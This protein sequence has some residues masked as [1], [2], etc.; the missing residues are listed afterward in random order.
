MSSNSSPCLAPWPAVL[1][2]DEH[3]DQACQARNLA[4]VN[5]ALAVVGRSVL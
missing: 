3:V 5:I 4:Y 1:S 2:F